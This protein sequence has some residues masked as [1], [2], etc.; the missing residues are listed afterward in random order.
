MGIP[1]KKEFSR[2]GNDYAYVKIWKF[3]VSIFQV[4]PGR[5]SRSGNIHPYVKFWKFNA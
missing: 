4:I 3:V 1:E 2:S 5:F